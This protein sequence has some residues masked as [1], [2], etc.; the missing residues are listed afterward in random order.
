MCESDSRRTGL[1]ATVACG[2]VTA[3]LTPASGCQD[4]TTSPSASASLV[5][6]AAASTASRLAFAT[7]MIRPSVG[8]DGGSPSSDLPDGSNRNIFRN[9]TCF[10][11]N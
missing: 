9:A 1:L 5:K 10:S 7:I 11:Q 2:Y 3:N 8:Q 6:E 4:H